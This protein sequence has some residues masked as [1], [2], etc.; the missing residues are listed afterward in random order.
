MGWAPGQN[1]GKRIHAHDFPERINI[2]TAGVEHVAAWPYGVI[3]AFGQSLDYHAARNSC[4]ISSTYESGRAPG[5]A[6]KFL[7]VSRASSGRSSFR[8][9]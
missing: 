5:L 4:S 2:F 3:T 9:R 7:S 8:N 6:L 1:Y